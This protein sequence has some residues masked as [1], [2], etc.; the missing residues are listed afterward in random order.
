MTVTEG[1]VM[2]DDVLLSLYGALAG[3]NDMPVTVL[4]GTRDEQRGRYALEIVQRGLLDPNC[5]C[6]VCEACRADA[7]LMELV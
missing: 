2:P 1:G 5:K 3:F 7:R 6:D 4:E